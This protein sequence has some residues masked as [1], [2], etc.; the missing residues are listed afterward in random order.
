MSTPTPNAS[1]T[2]KR[3]PLRVH[4]SEPVRGLRWRSA[5]ERREAKRKIDAIRREAE[6]R[7][8]KELRL[9]MRVLR[10][11]RVMM[12]ILLLFLIL[13]MAI[14]S[15]LKKPVKRR[16]DETL[17]MINRAT[18]SVKVAA[19]ALTFYRVH[20][21]QW[22][23]EQQGLAALLRDYG[24]Y[25]WKGPYINWALTDPWGTEYVYHAP[26][27][28]Y[29]A[30]ILFSCGPDTLPDTADDIRATPEDFVCDEGTWHRVEETDKQQTDSTQA[31]K[32]TP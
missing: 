5:E 23:R 16:P 31:E 26:A 21:L 2:P 30:P 32:V 8:I 9:D 14:T 4:R 15:V 18:R 12:G 20:T 28:R 17:M 24:T 13:G 11:P 27:S 25:G 3:T 1:P 7:R 6:A 10:S 19:Q 22:P 29:E